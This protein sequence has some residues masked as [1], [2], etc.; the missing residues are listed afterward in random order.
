MGAVR[1]RQE[2]RDPSI[3]TSLDCFIY[4]EELHSAVYDCV[5]QSLRPEFNAGWTE[6]IER[7][8][9]W[10]KKILTHI[11]EQRHI[12]AGG[13]AHEANALHARF[14]HAIRGFSTTLL[15][16]CEMMSRMRSGTL[17]WSGGSSKSL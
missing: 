15:L 7:L 13:D 12:M 17:S 16:H 5:T 14:I 8:N 4:S 6:T 9:H 2:L 1:V 3:W 11:P 10:R